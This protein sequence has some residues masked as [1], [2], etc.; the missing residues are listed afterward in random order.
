MTAA[1][2]ADASAA[3]GRLSFIFNLKAI[4][5][6]WCGREDSNF[7]ASRRYH[8]KVVRLPIPPRPHANGK[9]P[10]RRRGLAIR[11]RV[12]KAVAFPPHVAAGRASKAAST[13]FVA[14]DGR[15]EPAHVSLRFSP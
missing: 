15:G 6:E 13:I 1:R 3:Y 5:D 7:H 10:G 14:L 9:Y 11:S 2:Y 4:E 8:L 12:Y